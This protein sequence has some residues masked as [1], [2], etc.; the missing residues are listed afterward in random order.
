MQGKLLPSI[1]TGREILGLGI[2][3]DGTTLAAIPGDGPV[4]LWDL[5]E[6]K[7][8]SE[9]GGTGGYDTS[10]AVFS[11]DGQYL[12]ADLATGIF[13]WRVADGTLIWNDIHNSMAVSYSPNGLLAYSNIDDNNKV[14]LTGPDGK[15]II[16]EIEGMQ[17][18]V[19]ELFFSP[20][21]SL[22]AATDGIDIRIWQ[23]TDGS[24]LFIGKSTCP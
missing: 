12:A 16:R 1:Q 18:P 3:P 24:L 13:Q 7:M 11:P 20:D 17:G 9:L 22:L 23:V 5:A 21:S 10:D 8:T 2:S 14:T 19:W 6:N 4:S 15:R